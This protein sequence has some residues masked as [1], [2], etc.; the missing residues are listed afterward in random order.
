MTFKKENILVVDDNN[1][2]LDL[3]QRQLKSFNYR[4][5]KASS[6]NEAIDVLKNSE[7]DLLISDLN[8]PNINGIELLKYAE[9]HFPAIPKLVISGIPSVYNIVNAMKS[10]ALDYLTKPFTSEELHKAILESLN[11]KM[12]ASRTSTDFHHRNN[13]KSYGDLTG[14]SIQFKE[15]VE[16][17]E[18]IKDTKATVLIEGESGTGKELIARAI[19]FTSKL[20]DKPFIAV[21]CGSIP[22]NLIE[23]ELF[24]HIKGSFTGATEN[25]IGLFQSASGGTIFLD[26]IG[27]APMSL[28]VKLLRVIQEKEIVRVGAAKSEKVDVRIISATNSNLEEQVLKGSFREDLFYR[29]NVITIKTTPLRDRKEDLQTLINVFIEKYSLEY[30][31]TNIQI[32]DKAIEVLQRYNWPG[33]I[34][35]LENVIHRLVIMSDDSI[36]LDHIPENLKYHIPSSDTIFKSLKEYEKEQIIKV[37]NAVNNNKTKAAQILQIDRKTL[38]QKIQ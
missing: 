1:D 10:G 14:K 29:I 13:E 6:V 12:L 23:S 4:T 30:N 34:R 25:R 15:L 31:K 21:N 7:I 19:H 8:M 32:N 17:I 11:K 28:Q 20:R 2:M 27:D 35:E 5:Y 26:E 33:N 3:I 36:T 22:E 9:E 24:G 38:N 16:T 18:R 37:L